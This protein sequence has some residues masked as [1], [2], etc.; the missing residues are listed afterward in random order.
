MTI[1]RAMLI[2]LIT[3]S[4]SNSIAGTMS[5]NH[6]SSITDECQYEGAVKSDANGNIL[7]C[8]GTT[9]MAANTIA[10]TFAISPASAQL[11]K[12]IKATTIISNNLFPT[13]VPIRS[14][15]TITKPGVYAVHASI[16]L[17]TSGANTYLTSGI[18]VNGVSI[19]HQTNRS[20]EC[21]SSTSFT[22]VELKSGDTVSGYAGNNQ[23]LKASL[24][25]SI[26][27][28]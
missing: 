1:L 3:L 6:Y 8:N 24:Y 12:S 2:T 21:G 28:I 5:G 23:G 9:Y 19:E 27:K 11:P 17:C 26:T 13:N 18:K 10:Q 25:F 14:V 15:I 20:Q 22:A 7:Y 16:N 4:G